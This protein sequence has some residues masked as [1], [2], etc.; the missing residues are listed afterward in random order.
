MTEVL[1]YHYIY[2][3]KYNKKT[4]EQPKAEDRSIKPEKKV[5]LAPI[6]APVVIPEPSPKVEVNRFNFSVSR[7][8]SK[9]AK[10]VGVAGLALMVLVYAPNVWAW[11]KDT[12]QTNLA[13]F[14]LSKTEVSQLSTV[15]AKKPAY[16]PPYDPKLPI[17]N[18]L[19]IP[20][21]GVTTDLQEATYD[22]YEEALKKGVWRVSDFGSPNDRSRPTI[23]AAHRFGYLAWSNLYRRQNSF[24]NL[25][26]LKAG[27]LIEID[28]QQRKYQYEVYATATGEAITDYSGDLILYTCESLVGKERDFVYARLIET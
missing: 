28:Y 11:S 7:I 19:T 12:L 14:R 9:T 18:H 8:L 22:N 6:I 10:A 15:N 5:I 4:E 23:L 21:I 25:P 26:K 20:A 24:F 3:N 17:T 27:D 2:S 13:N 1:L 16:T